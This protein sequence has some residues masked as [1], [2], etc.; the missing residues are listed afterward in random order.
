MTKDTQIRTI[1]CIDESVVHEDENEEA[2][3]DGYIDKPSESY[4]Q[5]NE[6]KPQAQRSM[7]DFSLYASEIEQDNLNNS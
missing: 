4:K 5:I 3:R 6:L 2:A 7:R 1:D